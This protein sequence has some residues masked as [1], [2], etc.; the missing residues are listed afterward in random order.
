MA[1]FA[2]YRLG[3][4]LDVFRLADGLLY[5]IADVADLDPPGTF[6]A[7]EA[8]LEELVFR[9]GPERELQKNIEHI[10]EMLGENAT[11]QMADWIDRSGVMTPVERGFMHNKSVPEQVD[12]LVWGGG[13]ANWMLRRMAMTQRFDPEAFGKL[14]LPM[15][16]RK[17]KDTEHQLVAQYK[18]EHNRQPTEY[19]FAM[20][21]V[22][23]ILIHGG[24]QPAQIEVVDT[25]ES[26]GDEV[27]KT[28]LH[29]N[30][31]LFDSTVVVVANAP[32]A[33]QAAGQL[34]VAA[35][36][37]DPTFDSTG[38]QLFMVSDSFP[39][40]RAGEKPATH[41]NPATALGQLA[42]NALFLQRN[43]PDLPMPHQLLDE[44]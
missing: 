42:R 19:D 44:A 22:R 23:P 40:A 26:D 8:K 33:I 29:G 24:I 13:V 6:A 43:M 21:F 11:E 31:Q 25:Q 1:N 12:S 17:M 5:E 3:P 9:V 36:S 4:E 27:L 41:Q 20:R 30:R 10:R 35:R 18:K 7:T 38:D 34:R 37:L 28:F 32:N 16:T 14:Y 2:N 39:L 15:S